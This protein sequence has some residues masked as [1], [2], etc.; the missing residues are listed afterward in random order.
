[1]VTY[2]TPR[3]WIR[4]RSL[5][6]QRREDRVAHAA[7]A[8]RI[9]TRSLIRRPDEAG[10][11]GSGA[12]AVQQRELH[13]RRERAEPPLRSGISR[14]GEILIEHGVGHLAEVLLLARL[15]RASRLAACPVRAAVGGRVDRGRAGNDEV[16][17][18]RRG[19]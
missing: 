10:F 18:V 11:A 15:E 7:G 5:E 3:R 19:R 2:P 13:V 8:E 12:A 17:L 14:T 16:A 1:M 6:A 9:T 4:E